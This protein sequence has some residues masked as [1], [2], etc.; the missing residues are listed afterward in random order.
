MYEKPEL[1]ILLFIAQDVL[2]VSFG[3]WQDWED[4]NADP[5]GWV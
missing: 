1:E 4:P 3:G 2:E 5:D